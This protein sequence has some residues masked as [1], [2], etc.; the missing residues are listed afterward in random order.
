MI[1]DESDSGPHQVM[2]EEGDIT[3]VSGGDFMEGDVGVQHDWQRRL[4]KAAFRHSEP[5][6]ASVNAAKAAAKAPRGEWGDLL[7]KTEAKKVK[8]HAHRHSVA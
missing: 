5:L 6:E 3:I 7:K 1:L 8:K 2:N 4:G